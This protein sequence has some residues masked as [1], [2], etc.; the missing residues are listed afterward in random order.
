MYDGAAARARSASIS[1]S[2]L[3]LRDP[4]RRLDLGE[5]VVEAEPVVVD[6]AHVRRPALVALAAQRRRGLGSGDGD[7][8]PLARGQLLVGVEGEGR[9]VAARADLPA[10]GVARAERLAG[11]LEQAKSPLGGDGSNSGIAAG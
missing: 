1:S 10:L 6:P 8:A 7:H 9:E 4:D 5:P 2:A 11:I 3:E